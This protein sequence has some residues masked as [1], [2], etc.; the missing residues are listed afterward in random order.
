MAVAK[1]DIEHLHESDDDD[2]DAKDSES[3]ELGPIH[4]EP[5]ARIGTARDIAAALPL[6]KIIR[7][8]STD[9]KGPISVIGLKGERYYQGFIG[10]DTTYFEQYVFKNK[11]QC[12]YV[13]SI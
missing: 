2:I 12:Y 3:M 4:N 1:E 5:A 10:V 11:S 8:A 7:L 6:V 9:T 13:Y